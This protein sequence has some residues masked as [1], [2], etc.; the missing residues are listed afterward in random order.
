MLS[1]TPSDTD[2]FGGFIIGFLGIT[3]HNNTESVSVL[4][5]PVSLDHS[6]KGARLTLAHSF[7]LFR[8]T[9]PL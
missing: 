9:V 6:F 5:T 8:S 7:V 2:V 3:N 1:T 4:Q